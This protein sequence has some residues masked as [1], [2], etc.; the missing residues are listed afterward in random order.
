MGT[1]SIVLLTYFSTGLLVLALF[2]HATKRIRTRL[3]DHVVQTQLKMIEA[4]VFLGRKTGTAVFLIVTWLFWPAVLI[5]AVTREK[6][7][8]DSE[9]TASGY[10]DKEDNLGTEK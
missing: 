4:N 2:D 6:V 7:E 9:I 1:P 10:I 3:H 5:G 8:K